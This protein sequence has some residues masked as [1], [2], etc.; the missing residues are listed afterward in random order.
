MNK[1]LV[2]H[3]GRC[4]IEIRNEINRRLYGALT[5]C[6]KSLC[7]ERAYISEVHLLI[8]S[9]GG[10]IFWA[11]SILHFLRKLAHR[12]NLRV[13]TYASVKVYSA[14]NYVFMAGDERVAVAGT[15]FMQHP[16][17]QAITGWTEEDYAKSLEEHHR[18]KRVMRGFAAARNTMEKNRSN[19]IAI[20]RTFCPRARP[21]DISLWLKQETWFDEHEAVCKGIADRVGAIPHGWEETR[22]VL[23]GIQ[24][25]ETDAQR[26]W[27]HNR[28][29]VKWLKSLRQTRSDYLVALGP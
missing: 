13:F 28:T 25:N 29:I 6:L 9:E 14:A 18:T 27:W 24:R 16:A 5:T 19:S 1:K 3:S 15:L 23:T 22:I 2:T 12:Y 4:C 20:Y 26:S 21:S 8:D 11:Q 10:S 7:R 17:R